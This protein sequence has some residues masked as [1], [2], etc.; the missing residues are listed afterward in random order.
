MSQRRVPG[1]WPVDELQIVVRAVDAG[2]TY[3]TFRPLV[4]D[5]QVIPHRVRAADL[6]PLLAKLA[7]ALPDPIPGEVSGSKHIKRALDGALTSV[8]RERELSEALG[9]LVIPPAIWQLLAGAELPVRLRITPSARL[10]TLPWELLTLPRGERL[11]KLATLAFELP[12]TIHYRRPRRPDYGCIDPTLAPLR[13]IDPEAPLHT[14]FLR[15]MTVAGRNLVKQRLGTHPPRVID[16]PRIVTRED[17]GSALRAHPPRWLYFGHVSIPEPGMPGAAG[18]HLS[19]PGVGGVPPFGGSGRLYP[20]G[21]RALTVVDLLVGTREESWFTH[22]RPPAALG[23][24]GVDIWPMPP[25]VALIAC[26]SGADHTATEPL[27]LVAA[28][29]LL[30]AEIVTATRWSLPTDAAFSALREYHARLPVTE[31]V[32][33]VD[34]AHESADPVAGIRDWQLGQLAAWEASGD[35]GVAPLLFAALTTH[36]APAREADG[37]AADWPPFADEGPS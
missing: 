35:L 28:T 27:G 24:A 2:D 37:R 1:W 15:A 6:T 16:L 20:L 13:T 18:L 17:L 12:P 36:H 21:H 29:Q 22:E 34:A 23:L 25:R 9:R 31:L 11:L 10:A 30:G 7:E 32:L 3:L 4:P 33:A 8:T 19:D 5:A 26:N 14:P